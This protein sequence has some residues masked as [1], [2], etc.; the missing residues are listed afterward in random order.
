MQEFKYMRI[1]MSLIPN[2]IIFHYNFLTIAVNG[3][4][5]VEILHGMYGLLQA[6]ILTNKQLQTYFLTQGYYQV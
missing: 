6:S 5:M 4:V 2:C 3:Y 1:Q